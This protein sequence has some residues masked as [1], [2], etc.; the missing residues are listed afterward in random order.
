MMS[1]GRHGTFIGEPQYVGDEQTR[2]FAEGQWAELPIPNPVRAWTI[3]SWFVWERGDGPL[4]RADN[5]IWDW[6]WLYD[7][8]G[9]CAYRI[10]GSE[11]VTPL[12]T[13]RLIDGDWHFVSVSKQGPAATL[14]LD[15]EK[16]DTWSGAPL[17]AG[18]SAGVLMKDAIG[19]AKEF[20]VFEK[21]LP[22]AKLANLWEIG[23]REFG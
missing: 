20:A 13:S 2:H 23:S 14:W 6:G 10:G 1:G 19:Y 3:I 15:H 12:P 5:D 17:L 4:V 9:S 21:V 18:L 11:R 8:D 22:D 16:A 7:S